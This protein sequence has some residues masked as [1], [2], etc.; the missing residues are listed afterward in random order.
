MKRKTPPKSARRRACGRH[1]QASGLPTPPTGEQKQ[2]KRTYDV[3]PK[4]DNLIRYRHAAWRSMIGRAY[5]GVTKSNGHANGPRQD[6]DSASGCFGSTRSR[7]PCLSIR[8]KRWRVADNADAA[9]AGRRHQPCDTPSHPDGRA[10]RGTGCAGR[11]LSNP[12]RRPASRRSKRRSLEKVARVALSTRT[13]FQCLQIL[14]NEV[15]NE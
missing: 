3:L 5:R 12:G 8:G 6:V 4:P 11:P 10:S 15:Q 14:E 13:R 7:N 9:T 1:R 2:K